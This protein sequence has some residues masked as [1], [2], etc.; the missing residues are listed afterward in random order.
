LQSPT[1]RSSG[2]QWRGAVLGGLTALPS[3]QVSV[4]VA[5]RS[6]ISPS[7]TKNRP[8]PKPMRRR[9]PTN[10]STGNSSIPEGAVSPEHAQ[11][12][13]LANRIQRPNEAMMT[14][15][16]PTINRLSTILRLL[17]PQN[18]SRSGCALSIYCLPSTETS[19]R[20]DW[21]NPP[22]TGHYRGET[23]AFLTAPGVR[24]LRE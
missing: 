1:S 8:A 20:K 7:D 2:G 23:K 18:D 15:P 24:A 3:C 16:I 21:R 10:K 9:S 22:E 19:Q 11:L 17:I 13:E 6:M 5:H 4:D 14:P 12:E